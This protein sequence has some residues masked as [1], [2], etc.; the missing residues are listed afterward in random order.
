[1]TALDPLTK[2]ILRTE[3]RRLQ[4]FKPQID[5]DDIE[6]EGALGLVMHGA[7]AAPGP[8]RRIIA[9][10][11]MYRVFVEFAGAAKRSASMRIFSTHYDDGVD[12]NDESAR[13]TTEIVAFSTPS[14]EDDV[15]N[16]VTL[17]Q[18]RDLFPQ[19]RTVGRSRQ[20]EHQMRSRWIGN[21]KELVAA[22][23]DRAPPRYSRKVAA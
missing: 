18:L 1:M 22:G 5:T 11:H 16:R 20:A 19:P 15:I 3:A 9:R 6:Q 13:S 17:E 7:L 12:D 8:L 2:K 4:R 14:H 10:R 21:V 23:H